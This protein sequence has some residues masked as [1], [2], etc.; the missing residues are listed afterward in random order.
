VLGTV[1][2]MFGI[3]E[4]VE[5]ELTDPVPLVPSTTTSWHGR[6]GCMS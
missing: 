4:D 3:A 1:E 6:I 5:V 2:P